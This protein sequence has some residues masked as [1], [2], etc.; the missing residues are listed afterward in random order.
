MRDNLDGLKDIFNM[1]L[2]NIKVSEEL[3]LKTL[4]KLDKSSRRP[5]SKAVIPITLTMVACLFIGFIIYP[6]YNK[7]NL[8]H[9]EGIT[10]NTSNQEIKTLIEP[11]AGTAMVKDKTNIT[12]DK[13]SKIV[14]ENKKIVNKNSKKQKTEKQTIVLNEKPIIPFKAES[15]VP[16][17]KKEKDIV[18]AINGGIVDNEKSIK[19]DNKENYMVL[20][21]KSQLQLNEETKM[22]TISL[23]EA[24]NIFGESIKTSVY[25]PKAFVMEKILIPEENSNSSELYEIIYSNGSQYFKITQYKN[26]KDS[27][28]LSMDSS[29]ESKVVEGNIMV[30][31]INKIPVNYILR[32]NIDNKELPYVKLFLESEGEKYSV[33][34][35]APWAELINIAYY[36]LF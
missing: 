19:A 34:G 11:Y 8:M 27:S 35:N 9:N 4:G 31:N 24:K 26:M 32:P 3:K 6:I 16:E 1:E 12:E 25:I 17:D 10:M 5:I 13:P 22:R 2:K 29:P 36:I 20:Q 30:I 23:H 15:L 14:E 28:A 18:V 21:E 33:D 7:T